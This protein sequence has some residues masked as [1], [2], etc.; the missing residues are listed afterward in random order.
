M[1][2]AEDRTAG[3]QP[4]HPVVGRPAHTALYRLVPAAA[5][6]TSHPPFSSHTQSDGKNDEST[7]INGPHRIWVDGHAYWIVRV[8][9][10]EAAKGFGPQTP[11]GQGLTRSCTVSVRRYLG[12]GR[13]MASRSPTAP[14]PAESAHDARRMVDR[15]GCMNLLTNTRPISKN[16][17]RHCAELLP[18]RDQEVGSRDPEGSGMNLLQTIHHPSGAERRAAPNLAVCRFQTSPL[19][20]PSP[21]HPSGVRRC[22]QRTRGPNEQVESDQSTCASAATANNCT[23]AMKDEYV[24]NDFRVIQL[25]S[26]SRGRTGSPSTGHVRGNVRWRTWPTAKTRNHCDKAPCVQA[27][28][29][30]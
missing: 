11:P 8:S 22:T 5:G 6:L 15:G 19:D 18:G 17:G 29:G 27:G 9:A 16:L 10:D 7:S 20:C 4:L 14:R 23:M 12:A 26:R 1:I 24:G 2:E 25:R 30:A 28:K 3:H 13:A 21:A